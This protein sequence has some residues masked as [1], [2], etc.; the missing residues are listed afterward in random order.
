M[1]VAEMVASAASEVFHS[2][3]PPG[4]EYIEAYKQYYSRDTD[5]FYDPVSMFC[6]YV[7]TLAEYW[8]VLP[9]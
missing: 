5:Y 7:T 2:K 1:S 3:V 9:Q 4:F 8:S 6:M